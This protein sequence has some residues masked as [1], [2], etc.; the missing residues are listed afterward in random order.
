[1]TFCLGLRLILSQSNRFT[2]PKIPGSKDTQL[3]L[4]V[5]LNQKIENYI[6][7]D[8]SGSSRVNEIDFTHELCSSIPH[9]IFTENILCENI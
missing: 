2:T 5:Q 1:M 4:N 3:P 9:E 6:L 7:S 8:M